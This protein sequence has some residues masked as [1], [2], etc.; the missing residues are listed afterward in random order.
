MLKTPQSTKYF[1]YGH[2]YVEYTGSRPITEV[3]KRRARSV[4]EW[5]T[6]WEYRVLQTF[7]FTICLQSYVM[8]KTPQ[9]TKY[10][11]YGH[12]TLNTPV[13][14]RSPK[15]R[16]VGLGQYLN[17][18]PSGN[19]GCCR[20]LI[21]RICLQSY[22]MLKTPQSNTNRLFRLR[23]YYVEYTGS[24]PI[25]EVKKRRARSVLE[26]ETVW[27]YRVLQTFNFTICLQSYVMLKTP[28]ST[29]YFVY[30]H[31]TLNTPVLVRSPKLRNV[32]LGQ[33]LN[34][35]PSGNTGCCRLLILRF[36][37]KVM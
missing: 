18:R 9:S 28:Q 13:L 4:L 22:V 17:G 27:E 20:L 6:V 26:W 11:V 32:G 33:Y 37:Y 16:N 29:K 15:L 5:E 10:F 21:L 8:L 34:G 19:T 7:N 3:K 12:T 35:R 2:N 31:T 23:P 36:V 1:V 30:G 25:T 24:R 14:V